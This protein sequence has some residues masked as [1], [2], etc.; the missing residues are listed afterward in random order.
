MF[1]LVSSNMHTADGLVESS[2]LIWLM[3]LQQKTQYELTPDNV[4]TCIS[5]ESS[6]CSIM[7]LYSN[8]WHYC[9]WLLQLQMTCDIAA[10]AEVT[11]PDPK[12]VKAESQVFNIQADGSL[13]SSATGIVWAYD[14]KS[15]YILTPATL[16]VPYLRPECRHDLVK[17][18]H[19]SLSYNVRCFSLIRHESFWAKTKSLIQISRL[20][21]VH[22]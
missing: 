14:D 1:H 8:W 5:I 4:N 13:I 17:C 21:E 16:F 6:N 20:V 2:V 12:G 11:G 15:C 9:A 7:W 19:A 10:Y 18:N 22:I 3:A